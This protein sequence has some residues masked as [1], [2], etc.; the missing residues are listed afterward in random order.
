MAKNQ[1]APAPTKK[2]VSQ[3][4]GEEIRVT[5][6]D[7]G[8]A[9]IGDEPKTLP[10]RFWRAALK[11]GAMEAGSERLTP[12][13]RRAAVRAAPDS[14]KADDD[15]LIERI[16]AKIDEI[17]EADPNDPKYSEALTA[18]ETPRTDWLTAELGVNISAAQRDEAYALWELDQ[19]GEDDD[20]EDQE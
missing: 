20:E 10:E 13:Q 5:L 16:K 1:N 3:F 2:F 18:Q 4:E 15:G 14:D 19:D 12:A 17:F 9:L 11:A 8:V 6:P 7:G